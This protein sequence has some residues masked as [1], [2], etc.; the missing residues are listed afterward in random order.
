MRAIEP[1]KKTVFKPLNFDI[2]TSHRLFVGGIPKKVTRNEL[3]DYFLTYGQI[4][5]LHLSTEETDNECN[6]GYCFVTFKNSI[7]ARKVLAE[8]KNHV[9]RSKVVG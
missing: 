6:R 4:K 5:T 1:E 3:M 2:C 8:T 7:D 9:I